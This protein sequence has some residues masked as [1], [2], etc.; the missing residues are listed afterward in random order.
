LKIKRFVAKDMKSA[1]AQIKE[2]LG[3]DAVIMSNKRVPEGVEL[4][5]AVDNNV[6]INAAKPQVPSLNRSENTSHAKP[7]DGVDRSIE[8]DIVNIG[9]QKPFMNAPVKNSAS[10]ENSSIPSDS[11]A[12]LLNRQVQS[13]PANIG[14]GVNQAQHDKIAQAAAK[15]SQ[16]STQKLD[17]AS[18]PASS[19][20]IEQQ[21]KSFTD[22]LVQNN[23]HETTEQTVNHVQ[24]HSTDQEKPQVSKRNAQPTQNVNNDDFEKMKH[25]MSSIRELLEHQVSG[26]MWQ[27]MAQKDPSRAMLVNRL[28]S[29]GMN[30]QVSDQIA[31]YIPAQKNDQDT[32]ELAK[33]FISQQINTTNNDIIHRGGVVSLVG[34]T[35]VGKTTTVAKLAARFAQI[36]GSD[37]VV[38]IST[39]NYRIAGFEQLATYGRIIGCE[40]KLATDAKSLDILLQQFSKKKLILIDTAGM[41]Q[42]DMRLAKHLTTLVSNAR[43][44]IRN[45]LVLAAN[46]QQRVMQEN[47]DRFKKVPLAGC[48]YTKL[49]E[50]LS[51]GEII[52][53]S[54]QNGLAIGYL[55]DGQRV[56]EDIKVANADKLVTLADR[57][58]AKNQT[59]NP[60]NWRTAP[61]TVNTAVFP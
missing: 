60:I 47:V 52:C 21:L 50:S 7:N 28:M 9:Q 26:L 40:V 15:L 25:E 12:A 53:T 23:Q 46:T 41:G 27:D 54:I 37:Q 14:Q 1:L 58:T 61:T 49:D 17:A 31:G 16:N 5:A 56:P 36:H 29:L 11:L 38:M 13:G 51:I 45:Y 30:E 35:G 18:I 22:R 55:T 39:D 20:N 44:R 48:I 3:S 2:E 19:N 57:M 24:Q 10:V 33:K 59:N 42:R 32:W 6:E 34:P 8:N 43:V 4:M